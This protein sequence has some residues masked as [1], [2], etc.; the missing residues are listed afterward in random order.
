MKKPLPLLCLFA[1][2]SVAFVLAGCDTFQS[3][4]K[5]KSEVY[6]S[7][8]PRTQK[9]LER[10]KIKPGDTTDMVYIA[11]GEP[12]EK[13]DVTTASGAQ[14]IWIYRT[15]WEQYEGSAWVGWHRAI[16][17][18]AGGGY[19]IYHEPITQDIY[20]T[21]IDEVIRVTFAD[22]KVTVLEQQKR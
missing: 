17:P 7:L 20:R 22:G 4:A 13:R 10:G 16:E 8:N 3:R 1:V 5:E 14:S 15:Y 18:M 9:R 2:L 6:D 21:H 12:D 19:V 11:L